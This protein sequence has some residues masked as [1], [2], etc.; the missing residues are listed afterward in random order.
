MLT[1]MSVTL[2][3]TGAI[4][5]A[6]V[7]DSVQLLGFRLRLLCIQCDGCVARVCRER[8]GYRTCR[9]DCQ[10]YGHSSCGHSNGCVIFLAVF[11][12]FFFLSGVLAR[13][14]PLEAYSCM[15]NSNTV[16]STILHISF[17]YAKRKAGPRMRPCFQ[18]CDYKYPGEKT[19]DFNRGMIAVIR[20]DRNRDRTALCGVLG[21]GGLGT[22]S[23]RIMCHC[24]AQSL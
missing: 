17:A 21:T 23:G 11:F 6:G 9:A 13:L 20:L 8:I 5:I 3:G 2:R 18:S 19:H 7:S 12:H 14:P 1:V 10:R 15:Y 24:S 16:F 22:P 4:F